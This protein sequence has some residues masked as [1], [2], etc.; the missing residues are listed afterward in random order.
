MGVNSVAVTHN[1]PRLSFVAGRNPVYGAWDPYLELPAAL[2]AIELGLVAGP[3]LADVDHVTDYSKPLHGPLYRYRGLV[4]VLDPQQFA[5]AQ[6]GVTRLMASLPGPGEA[7]FLFLRGELDAALPE[8]LAR[9]SG[10]IDSDELSGTFTIFEVD[11]GE[12]DGY[13]ALF[14]DY[15]RV[16]GLV[17]PAG[18]LRALLSRLT[19]AAAIPTGQ[20]YRFASPFQ[21]EDCSALTRVLEHGRLF[22]EEIDNGTRLRI[23]AH[24]AEIGALRERL[25]LAIAASCEG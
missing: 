23:I 12:L 1:V 9:F 19:L 18:G 17:A 21:L 13:A 8:P 6:A 22:F 25:A 20:R 5:R 7:W 15:D 2:A 10:R 4:D 3:V 11:E 24:T 14:G 16:A